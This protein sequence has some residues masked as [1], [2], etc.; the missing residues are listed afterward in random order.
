M[1]ETISEVFSCFREIPNIVCKSTCCNTITV[2]TR[3]L[4]ARCRQWRCYPRADVVA[5]FDRG[6][7]V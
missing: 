7:T 4:S 5:D 6:V 3:S 1:L 2:L